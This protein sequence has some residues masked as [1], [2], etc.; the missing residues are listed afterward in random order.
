MPNVFLTPHIA[1]VTDAAEFRFF[2]L[3]VDEVL[4][5]LAW[6]PPAV[7]LCCRVSHDQGPHS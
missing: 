6:L 2:S 1:G 7:P 5:V 4:R 3:M